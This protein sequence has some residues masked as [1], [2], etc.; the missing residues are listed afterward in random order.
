MHHLLSFLKIFLNVHETKKEKGKKAKVCQ[1]LPRVNR[2]KSMT[3]RSCAARVRC[4][5]HSKGKSQTDVSDVV[6]HGDVKLGY[7]QRANFSADLI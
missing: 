6:F 1:M 7:T 4:E 5:T 2:L 3:I